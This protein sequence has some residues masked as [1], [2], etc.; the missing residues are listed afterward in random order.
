MATAA[1]REQLSRYLG[2]LEL[3]IMLDVW[4]HGPSTV[5][6]VLDRLNQGNRKSLAYNTIMSTLSRL[7]D[8]GH[9]DREREGRAY[10]Y[11]GEGPEAFLQAQA[12]QAT[13][14]LV[15]GLGKV[16]VAGVVEGLS[17]SRNSR[18]LMRQVLDGNA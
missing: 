14:E 2:P 3:R 9:L 12:A 18:R 16:G 6:E 8:K 5:N 7:A 1:Q 10:V 15:E 4:E 17:A 11:S 13:R